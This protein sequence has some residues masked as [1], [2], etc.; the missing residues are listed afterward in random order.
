MEHTKTPWLAST[1]CDA[2]IAKEPTADHGSFNAQEVAHY[3]GYVIAESLSSD[4]RT[5]VL[6]ACN[7]H[8]RLVEA[9]IQVTD[10]L[11]G[12]GDLPDSEMNDERW[13]ESQAWKKVRQAREVLAEVGVA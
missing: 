9:L 10:V 3:G 8:E 11:D 4:D 1:R 12:F 6:L 5:F 2:I 7:L 13:H